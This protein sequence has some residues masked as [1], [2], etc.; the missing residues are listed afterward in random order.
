MGKFKEGEWYLVKFWDHTC[1]VDKLVSCKVFGYVIKQDKLS[2]TLSWWECEDPEFKE[3][4][5]EIVT[6][7][8]STLLRVSKVPRQFLEK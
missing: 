2:V 8:K 1:G 5:Q 4:N 7:L 3:S 6:L